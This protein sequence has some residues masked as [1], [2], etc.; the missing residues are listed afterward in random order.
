MTAVTQQILTL[1]GELLGWKPIRDGWGIGDLRVNGEKH[2]T[3]VTGTLVGVRSGDAVELQ[4][5][6]ENNAKFGPQFKVKSCQIIRAEGAQG[7][8]KWMASRF[9]GIGPS[10]A[11]EI[12]ERFGDDLWR[13]YAEEPHRLA[14]IKGITPEL[15]QK[16]GETYKLVEH[17]RE[18][19]ISLRGWGLTDNQVAQCQKVWGEDLGKVIA[20][21]RQ[22]PYL[23]SQHVYGFGFL[24]ADEIAKKMGVPL[25]SPE[26]V[27]AGIDHL[28]E[29]AAGEGHCF[30]AGGRL[31]TEGAKMLGVDPGLIAQG[32]KAA[33]RDG[34]V[35]RRAWR[36][37]SAKLDRAEAKLAEGI[38]R[39]LESANDRRAA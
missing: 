17:E 26:R 22:N 38:S 27:K 14:E 32:M 34:R 13:I 35:I 19:M 29:Q 24:R 8:V 39:L 37:Y 2:N 16:I 12:T 11:A 6:F 10:R 33:S 3:K 31:Q 4:G 23:L 1:R 9:P 5:F 25:D 18:H 28:L 21:L 36:W 30:I 7:A 20:K 15:A